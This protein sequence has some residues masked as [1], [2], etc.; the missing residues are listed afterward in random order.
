MLVIHQ[1]MVV[2]IQVEYLVRYFY[3]YKY[4]IIIVIISELMPMRLRK[5]QGLRLMVGR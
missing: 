4:F 2:V 3:L 5:R 1:Q